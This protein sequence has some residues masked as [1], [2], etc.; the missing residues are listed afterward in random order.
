[1]HVIGIIILS[2]LATPIV[3]FISSCSSRDCECCLQNCGGLALCVITIGVLIDF[4]LSI[5]I[6]AKAQSIKSM[7]MN[8]ANFGDDLTNELIKTLVDDYSR[9][10]SLSLCIIILLVILVCLF[11]A[12]IILSYNREETEEE[13]DKEKKEKLD[14]E[15]TPTETEKNENIV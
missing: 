10:Y 4:I 15:V 5:I 9:N 14:K 13:A 12:T 2:I 1:M 8:N 11:I 7:L 3:G 6:F